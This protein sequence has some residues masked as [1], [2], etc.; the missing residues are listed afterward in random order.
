MKAK[1][2][3]KRSLNYWLNLHIILSSLLIVKSAILEGEK[4]KPH[5]NVETIGLHIQIS[6]LYLSIKFVE[7]GVGSV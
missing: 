3:G 5:L 6:L 2:G 7:S 4:I 1:M